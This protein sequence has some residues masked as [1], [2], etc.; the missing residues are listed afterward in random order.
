MNKHKQTLSPENLFSITSDPFITI[1][2]EPSASVGNQN[3][4]AP[5]VKS[6]MSVTDL[7]SHNPND[8]VEDIADYEFIRAYNNTEI[9]KLYNDDDYYYSGYLAFEGQKSTIEEIYEMITTMHKDLLKKIRAYDGGIY[10]DI[11]DPV[12]ENGFLYVSYYGT[13]LSN[14]AK[15]FMKAFPQLKTYYIS[16]TCFAAKFFR[17]KDSY[18][19]FPYYYSVSIVEPCDDVDINMQ[20]MYSQYCTTI[21]DAFSIIA[22]VTKK[23]IKS[24]DDI[25]ALNIAAYKDGDMAAITAYIFDIEIKDHDWLYNCFVR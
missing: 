23:P 9:L 14:A 19:P 10:F 17:N 2:S 20:H 5:Y 4:E 3:I 13:S 21:E 25:E 15:L 24:F 11:C 12:F 6:T 1:S 22:D 8:A 7:P 18:K 16:N